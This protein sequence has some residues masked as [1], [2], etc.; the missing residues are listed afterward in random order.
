MKK[1]QLTVF[2]LLAAFTGTVK[3]MELD[4]MG[5][6]TP[7]VRTAGNGYGATAFGDD[8][9]VQPD[10]DG[11][12]EIASVGPAIAWQEPVAS[13]P[14]VVSDGVEDF[15]YFDT[16]GLDQYGTKQSAEM[17]KAFG[18]ALENKFDEIAGNYRGKPG[19]FSTDAL[20]SVKKSVDRVSH[21]LKNHAPVLV[22]YPVER[23]LV[24][25]AFDRVNAQVEQVHDLLTA[26]KTAKF[27]KRRKRTED[28][29][30]A[31]NGVIAGLQDTE[32][33]IQSILADLNSR[34]AA[35][36]EAEYQADCLRCNEELEEQSRAEIRLKIAEFKNK[37]EVKK[38][39]NTASNKMMYDLY[40]DA[41]AF[42]LYRQAENL[43]P[44]E[45]KNALWVFANEI[46][47]AIHEYR[48]KQDSTYAYEFTTGCND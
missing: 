38:R 37:M 27:W 18:T 30:R 7:L 48:M 24:K 15:L 29:V 41:D 6:C 21:M 23:L 25:Q 3:T 5:E 13:Q 36:E 33:A 19:H 17:L 2:M 32:S 44:V 35:I 42:I 10:G 45:E 43:L 4:E 26:G 9:A 40:D 47:S 39:Q 1:I 14:L 16:T 46:Q 22:K 8:M 34:Q 20:A 31:I 11:Y 28:N 12:I